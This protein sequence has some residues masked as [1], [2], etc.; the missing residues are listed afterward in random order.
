MKAPV[1]WKAAP[2]GAEGIENRCGAKAAA[3]DEFAG[4]DDPDSGLMSFGIDGVAC[5]CI[6]LCP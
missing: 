2:A 3:A 6:T 1:C 4:I 5:P